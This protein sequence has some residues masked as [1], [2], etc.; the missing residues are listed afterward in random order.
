MDYTLSEKKKKENEQFSD[1]GD[2]VKNKPNFKCKMGNIGIY[3]I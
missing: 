1:W 3:R 2:I